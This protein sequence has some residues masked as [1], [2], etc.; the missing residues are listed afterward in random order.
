MRHALSLALSLLTASPSAAVAAPLPASPP[1]GALK[2]ANDGYDDTRADADIECVLHDGGLEY[3]QARARLEAHPELATTRIAARRMR[4]PALDP[5]DRSQ[6]EALA[7]LLGG[8]VAGVDPAQA[9]IPV[10]AP[11]RGRD[12]VL[13]GAILLGVSV[14]LIL[15]GVRLGVAA[16]FS[17]GQ[18]VPGSGAA[19]PLMGIGAA[20][21][22]A[23]IPL[24]SVGL[25]RR[26]A[27]R[28]WER[29]HRVSLRPSLHHW[30]GS[31]SLTLT[32]HF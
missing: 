16:G 5:E 10:A 12:A 22:L 13:G 6:L 21:L 29:T 27:W 2:P 25:Y 18:D 8:P 19:V 1:S 7:R 26:R 4:P 14:P 30:R 28:A 11:S 23:G 20:A 15:I 9:T 31:S 24:L 3:L 17:E 32:L